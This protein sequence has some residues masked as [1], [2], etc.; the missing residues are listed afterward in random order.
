M[1]ILRRPGDAHL[2]RGLGVQGILELGL[3]VK[4]LAILSSRSLAPGIPFAM[5]AAWAAIFAAM[6]P[7]FTSSR[8]GSA[9][10]SAGVT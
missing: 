10:C 2:P 9:R 3:P 5:S 7:C 1:V 8:L 6:I 4:L